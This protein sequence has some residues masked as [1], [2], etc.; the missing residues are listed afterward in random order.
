VPGAAG[1]AVALEPKGP[2]AEIVRGA[3]AEAWDGTEPVHMGIGGSIPFISDI[4]GQF[5]EATIAVVGP[6][7][8][9][10]SWH[11]PDESVDLEV[12]RRLTLAEV[13]LLARL[14]DA[15]S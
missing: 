15:G 5:P 12:L 6:G 2:R 9:A 8:P 13:L 3:F 4:A 7:D 1:S 11:G 14:G 10:A